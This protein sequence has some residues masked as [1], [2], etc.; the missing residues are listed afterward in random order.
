MLIL[1][2]RKNESIIINGN[3][4]ITYLGLDNWHQAKIGI[5]APLNLSIHREE[6]HQ[7]IKKGIEPKKREISSEELKHPS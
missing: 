1:C 3:I 2:R 4:K 7:R 5:E 6:V